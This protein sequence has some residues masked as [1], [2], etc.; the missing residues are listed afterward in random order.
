MKY[1]YKVNR[2]VYKA[3]FPYAYKFGKTLWLEQIDH[4]KTRF[5]VKNRNGS[6]YRVFAGTHLMLLNEM[7]DRAIKI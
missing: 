2:K 6:Y 7:V 1:Q 4:D 3:L 5:I